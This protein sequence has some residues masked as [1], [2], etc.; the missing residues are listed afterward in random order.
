MNEYRVLTGMSCIALLVALVALGFLIYRFRRR[1][2]VQRALAPFRRDKG[3]VPGPYYDMEKPG[4]MASRSMT[5]ETLVGVSAM[6]AQGPSSP[7]YSWAPPPPH[8]NDNDNGNDNDN[9]NENTNT[10]TNTRTTR[11]MSGGNHRL[12]TVQTSGLSPIPGSISPVSQI[13]QDLGSDVSPLSP[14]SNPTYSLPVQQPSPISSSSAPGTAVSVRGS[15]A[16]IVRI[17]PRS[18]RIPPPTDGQGG[19]GE[20]SVASARA[21][22]RDSTSAELRPPPLAIHRGKQQPPVSMRRVPLPGPN[23]TTNGGFTA[24][25]P[26]MGSRAQGRAQG[27]TPR[28]TSHG[29]R[30]SRGSLSG[31]SIASSDVLFTPETMQWPMPPGTPPLSSSDGRHR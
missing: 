10:N 2:F 11:G 14:L 5:G 23:N 17:P 12:L 7:A 27:Y 6:R 18:S 24:Y 9:D 20:G 8:D 3:P 4:A 19:V 25:H 26:S 29:S 30:A 21:S 31:A 15:D 22:A 28:R 16:R 13:S 1:A